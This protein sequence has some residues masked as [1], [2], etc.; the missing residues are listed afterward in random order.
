MSAAT[1]RWEDLTEG[2]THPE[3][4]VGPVTRTDIVRYQG[5]SGDMNPVHHDETFARAA[6]YE[7]PLGVG[8]FHAGI[9]A[10]WATD[11]LGA[12][13]VRA[14]KVRWKEPVWPGDVLIFSGRVTR[15][16]PFDEQSQGSQERERRVEIE[17]VCSREGGGVAAQA[18]AVFVV[19]R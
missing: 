15:R 4:R 17:I 1:P 14:F 13:N 11:W 18:T 12:E 10:T 19:T 6:G 3:R 8:M 7:A 16:L 5:A 9:M 2:A